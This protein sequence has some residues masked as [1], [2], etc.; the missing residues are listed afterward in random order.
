MRI[1]G[2]AQRYLMRMETAKT[3]ARKSV[4]RAAL[5]AHVERCEHCTRYHQMVKHERQSKI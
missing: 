2:I 3:L 1:C 5:R 4:I